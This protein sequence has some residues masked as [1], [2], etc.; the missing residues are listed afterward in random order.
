MRTRMMTTEYT[1]RGSCSLFVC[2][3]CRTKYGWEHQGWCDLYSLTEP[4]CHDCR[5]FSEQAGECIHPAQK[6]EGRDLP[7]E[8]DECPI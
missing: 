6:R 4:S 2:R 3:C 1:I 5:Y 8:E 7:Y